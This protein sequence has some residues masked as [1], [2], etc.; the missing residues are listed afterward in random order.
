MNYYSQPLSIPSQDN[1]K[2]S[3]PNFTKTQHLG[4]MIS[5][6]TMFKEGVVAAALMKIQVLWDITLCR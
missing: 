4:Y 3:C 2:Q 6:V 1:A 5:R